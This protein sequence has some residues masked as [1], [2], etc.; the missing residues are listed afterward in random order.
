MGR[1]KVRTFMPSNYQPPCAPTGLLKPFFHCY[2]SHPRA[3]LSAGSV[4]QDLHTQ[5]TR[6]RNKTH[7]KPPSTPLT[8]PL[9]GSQEL[10]LP[11]C[12]GDAP[13]STSQRRQTAHDVEAMLS[14]GLEEQ[15]RGRVQS[16][17]HSGGVCRRFLVKGN[18][19]RGLDHCSLYGAF[20]TSGPTTILKQ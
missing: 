10:P 3:G 8:G 18:V 6:K 5:P 19:C 16:R 12:D 9:S 7:D 17:D 20:P 2:R 14:S 11:R 13:D 4:A 1:W 15:G